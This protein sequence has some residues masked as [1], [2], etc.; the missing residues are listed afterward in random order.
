M[1]AQETGTRP[2]R[3]LPYEL[4]VFGEADGTGQ[5]S[6]HFVNTG[7]VAAVFQVRSGHPGINPRTYTVEPNSKPSDGWIFKGN[8]PYDLTVYGPNGFLRAFKGSFAGTNKAEI[9]TAI[10]YDLPGEWVVLSARNRGPAVCKAR[11]VDVYTRKTLSH[12]IEPGEEWQQTWPL[13][14]TFGWYDFV[15]EAESDPGFRHQLAG[16]L[17]TGTDSMSDPAIGA[18]KA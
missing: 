5:F 1:P 12:S 18:A 7:K 16:H 2:A 6:L 15:V 17:E 9:E 13:K 8:S 10:S 3:A 11:L 14:D 4:N